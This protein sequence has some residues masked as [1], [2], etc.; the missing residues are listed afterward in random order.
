MQYFLTHQTCAVD[1]CI[2]MLHNDFCAFFLSVMLST[3]LEKYLSVIMRCR[4]RSFSINHGN[5]ML[6]HCQSLYSIIVAAVKYT[7]TM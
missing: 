5:I 6:T 1:K 4:E 7:A 3:C 2:K